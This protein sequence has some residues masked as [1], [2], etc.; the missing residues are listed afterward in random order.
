MILNLSLYQP[1]QS[2]VRLTVHGTTS[3]ARLCD[4]PAATTAAVLMLLA[5]LSCAS[6]WVHGRC[7]GVSSVATHTT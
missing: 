5:S 2:A 4:R 7:A 6:A 1:P 3:M